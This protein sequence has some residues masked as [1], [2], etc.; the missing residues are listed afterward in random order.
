MMPTSKF[1]DK[2]QD[3]CDD[4]SL[5]SRKLKQVEEEIEEKT[6]LIVSAERGAKI[7]EYQ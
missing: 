2:A 4:I 7:I 1:E 3:L 5:V 6:H